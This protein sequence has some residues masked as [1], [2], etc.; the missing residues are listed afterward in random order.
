MRFV[1]KH[2]ADRIKSPMVVAVMKSDVR[3]IEWTKELDGWRMTWGADNDIARQTLEKKAKAILE[4][5]QE[6]YAEIMPEGQ[7]VAAVEF[8]IAP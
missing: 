1:L 8:V 7:A 6:G 2:F 5:A 4:I 3:W